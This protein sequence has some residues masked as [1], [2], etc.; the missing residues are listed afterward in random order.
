MST[1]SLPRRR[2]WL[3]TVIVGVLV[4]IFLFTILAGFIV[5]VLW[6]DEIHQSPVFWH[7]L[8]TKIWLGVVFGALFFALLYVNLVIARRIRPEET[9]VPNPL[10]PLERVRDATEPYLRWLLP[11]GAAALAFL[12]GLSVSSNWQVYLLWRNASGVA[13]GNPEPL[14]HRD[15]AFYVF[16]LPWLR[17]L[18]GWLFSSLIGVTLLVAV[19]HVLWGGIRPQAPA[20][21]DKVTPAARAHLSVLLGLV[22]LVKAWGYWLG[23]FDL[24]TSQRGVVE[25]ASYTEVK[26][27][28]PALNFLTLV[29]VICALL[30][31]LNIRTKQ[32]SLPIVAVALLAIVS[33]LLGTAYPAFVQQFKVKPNEQQLESPYIGYNIDATSDAFGLNEIQ[34]QSRETPALP[35]SAAQLKDNR[36]TVSNIRL[37]RPSTLQKNFA[38][39]QQIRQYYNFLDVDVDRYQFADE[40]NPRVIMVS[41]RELNPAGI[42]ASAQT[43]QN[44]HLTYTHGFGA[45]ASQVNTAT[46]QGQPVLT[47]KNLPSTGQPVMSEQRIYY[48]EEDQGSFVVAGAQGEL[49]YDGAPQSVPYQGSGGIPID[50]ILRRLLF[51]WNFRDINLLLSNQITDSSRLM[52][53]RNIEQR[54][55]KAVPFLR[56][57]SDPYLAIVDG[58]P[59][60]ILDA[61]TTTNE[62]PYSEAVSGS[63]ATDGLLGGTFNYIRNSV[64]VVV[65]AYTGQ[66]TYW[67]NDNDPIIQVWS[68]AF[69]GLFQS[70]ANAPAS[71]QAHFRYPE[72]LFQVQAYQFANYHVTDPAAF[73]QRRDFWQVSPDPTLA[74]DTSGT[75]PPMRP[76]YQLIRL[77]DQETE[78]FQLVIPFV[79]AGR[80]NM[81]G[82]MAANSDPGEQYGHITMFR[83]PEGSTTSI[84]GPPQVFARINNDPAFSSFRTL[85]GQQ[86]ST[87]S[88]GDFLVIPVDDSFLYVLPVYVTASDATP[89]IPELKRVI[90]VNGSEGDVSLGM[91]LPDA[92]G[93]ATS[94]VS[95]EGGNGPGGNGGPTGSVDQ[96]IQNLLNQAL[97]HF[98]A[99]DTALTNGDL[100]TYQSELAQAQALVQQAQQLAAS[101]T[102]GAG[103]GS[104][105]T[106]PTPT[107][108]A[109]ASPP[110]TASPSASP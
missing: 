101:N 45:V 42:Q 69:P 4:A 13:F 47:L 34:Q 35:L 83:F 79:P 28:L 102:G 108:S 80:P 16:S 49:D 31:F 23:R 48:G 63:A 37:W 14:F 61:Y 46:V 24:L 76:Y 66:V 74:P 3:S 29:A 110:I 36:A 12:V 93:I 87:L 33:V 44:T 39:F 52:I 82:W 40:K 105:T 7:T 103:S 19:G 100:G 20:F 84:E 109:T 57:D 53:Y 77:P 8:S 104:T 26:A 2:R 27:Q 32:W 21:A 67:A 10:D 18:Q 59:Q 107:P 98:Q 22:M 62:Y 9:I 50:N 106:S 78:A 70:I 94:G 99:A 97:T 38:A 72:N 91:S 5:E 30:F 64:K 92:L 89:A 86:G 1:I 75:P 15:P 51:A 68:K 96:Q 25:G 90:V 81:V 11:L 71:L 85:V 60:W 41:A 43:W 17:F 58:Q 65:D 54:A 6:Y 55:A 95:T 73:Y 88:F 56:F